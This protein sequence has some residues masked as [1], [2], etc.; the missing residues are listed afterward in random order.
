MYCEIV[1]WEDRYVLGGYAKNNLTFIRHRR[2]ER[3][4]VPG[5]I[6]LQFT[7]LSFGTVIETS[8]C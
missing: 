1:L 6:K 8:G 3:G 5:I 4:T 2:N 7:C